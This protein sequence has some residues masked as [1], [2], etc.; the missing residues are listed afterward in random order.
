MGSIMSWSSPPRARAERHRARVPN[1]AKGPV[2]SPA[3]PAAQTTDLADRV[4]LRPRAGRYKAALTNP[5]AV[6]CLRR[7]WPQA[8]SM[9]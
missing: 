7:S 1:Q 2:I 3:A 9:S 4:G 8:A 5:S 6:S